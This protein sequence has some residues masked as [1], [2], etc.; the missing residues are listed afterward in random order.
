MLDQLVIPVVEILKAI[1]S[2][3]AAQGLIV[4]SVTEVIK[5]SPVGPSGGSKVRILAAVLAVATQLA[6][7]ASNGDI[8]QFNQE[9]VAKHLLDALTVLLS[10]VGAWQL[11]KKKPE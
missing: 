5:A 3:P 7:A 9:E 2:L 11:A 1:V 6:M 4:A 10:A 8:T